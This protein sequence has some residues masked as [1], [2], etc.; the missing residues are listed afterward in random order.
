MANE[1]DA[2]RSDSGRARK[3]AK[4]E[5]PDETVKEEESGDVKLEERD[6]GVQ[7]PGL[8]VPV[9]TAPNGES[10]LELGKAKRVTVRKFKGSVYIDIREFYGEAGDEKPGKKGISLSVSQWQTLLGNVSEIN[11]LATKLEA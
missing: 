1:S 3:K 9:L 10:Y 5:H 4:L 7:Q 8:K 6:G 11:D 2:E